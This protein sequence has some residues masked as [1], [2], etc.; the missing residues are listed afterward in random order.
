MAPRRGWPEDPTTGRADFPEVLR[1]PD[2][3]VVA[4]V[5]TPP[6]NVTAPR[7]ALTRP[8]H[9]S[10]TATERF[11]DDTQ[12]TTGAA[13]SRPVTR[14]AT[15]PVQRAVAAPA[16]P[17][18]ISVLGSLAW[19]MFDLFSKIAV[20]PPVV[21]AG[22]AVGAGRSKL[23]IDCGP[24]RAVDADW[25]H[26]NEGQPD[27]LIYFQ[28]GFLANAAVYNE[29]LAELADRNNA[30]VV[31]PT[32]TSDKFDCY[33]CNLYADP[34]HAAVARL[35]VGDRA[36]LAA[37]AAAAGYDGVLP[38]K[39]VIAGQ[40]AGTQLAAGAAGYFYKSAAAQNKADLVGVLLYDASAATGALPRALA[41]LPASVP[42]LQ[43]AAEPS[44][45]N[46]YGNGGQALADARPGEFNGVQLIGGAHS[47]GF[48]TTKFAGLLQ[49][50]VGFVFGFSSPQNVEVVQDLSQ[51][52]ISDMYA[53]TVY[54]DAA[55]SGIYGMP[56]Q[57]IDIA[58]D[59]GT[60]AH[61]YVLPAPLPRLTLIKRIKVAALDW[62][63]NLSFAYCASESTAPACTAERG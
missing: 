7:P 16:R 53:G 57:I 61:A 19:G 1:S 49:V 31:A 6:S 39:F 47:D 3:E 32:I 30:V 4:A 48:R 40:S 11:F 18:L 56:G 34:M 24:G 43:I 10:R 60:D 15:P 38:E 36:A 28:H 51:G 25:Y 17:R 54:D 2:A 20:G 44:A 9:E 33:G 50:F 29:T 21:P 35:F 55:R 59:A 37:S 13:P 27:K 22:L 58:T 5:T 26:P 23:A 62:F 45:I 52:W 41:E 63:G 8:K 46:L 14:L 12:I 42:V